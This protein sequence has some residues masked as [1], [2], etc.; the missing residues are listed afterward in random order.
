MP[1]PGNWSGRVQPAE[2]PEQPVGLLHVE[3]GPVV[4]HEDAGRF[5]AELD[6][7][8]L[9]P[10]RVLPGVADEVVDDDA[11]QAGVGAGRHAV[12]D[13][14][15]HVVRRVAAAQ[16][17]HRTVGHGGQVDLLAGQLGARTRIFAIVTPGASGYGGAGR[18]GRTRP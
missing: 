3:A 2:G 12:L 6:R 15:G 1:V 16:L 7:G 11:H 14:H 13:D 18:S 5:P 10:S 8:P 4:A 9:L 17:D